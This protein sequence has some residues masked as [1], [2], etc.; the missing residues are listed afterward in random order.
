MMIKTLFSL[1]VLFI[2][3]GCHEREVY[4][5]I[6]DKQIIAHPPI[7]INIE[8]PSGMLKTDFRHDLN[9][10]M[11]MS[12][13]V[14]CAKCTNAQTKSLGAD[15]DGYIRITVSKGNRPL[16]RAQMDYKGE[17]TPEEV[18]QVYTHLMEKLQWN[19]SV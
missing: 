5:E 10:P 16:A 13:M 14:H 15:F 6:A 9:A 11:T 4:T 8:D 12:L 3:S 7:A 19:H 2:L 1:F 17:A 18:M